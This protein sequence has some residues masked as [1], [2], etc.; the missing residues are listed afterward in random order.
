MSPERPCHLEQ[1]IHGCGDRADDREAL[2]VGEREASASVRECHP[3][4][5]R[6]E[7]QSYQATGQ[8]EADSVGAKRVALGRAACP[9]RIEAS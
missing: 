8:T 7:S 2:R 4:G 1:F 9:I 5:W 3:A 6:R